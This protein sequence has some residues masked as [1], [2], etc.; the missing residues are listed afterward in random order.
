MVHPVVGRGLRLV[1]EALPVLLCR[2]LMRFRPR[3]L[4]MGDSIRL[5][6]QPLVAEQMQHRADVVGP[7]EN[8]RWAG[9]TLTR[10]PHCLRN[11]AGQT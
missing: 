3:I 10:L 9:H 2:P 4:L 8:G 6:Y 5:S 7:D 1:L 11:W